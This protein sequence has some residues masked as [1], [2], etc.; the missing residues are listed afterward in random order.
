MSNNYVVQTGSAARYTE[1]F[2]IALGQG[3]YTALNAA[4]AYA[5]TSGVRALDKLF[6]SKMGSAWNEVDKRWLVGIDWCRSDPPAL[7][8]LSAMPHST[9]R[10]PD[11][12]KTVNRKGC[13]PM[14]TYHPKLFTLIGPEKSA[15]ICGSGNLSAN[16][17]TKGCECGSVLVVDSLA[18]APHPELTKLMNWF[19]STWRSATPYADINAIYTKKAEKAI[20]DRQAV[21]TDDDVNPPDH[22]ARDESQLRK[23]CTYDNLWIDAG[24]LGNNLGKGKPGNQLD[25]RRYTRVFFG[26][27]A[28]E[29]PKM[30]VIDKLVLVWGGV[31]YSNCTLKYGDN[32]M[33]KLNVPPSGDRGERFYEKKTLLFTRRTNGKFDFTAGDLADRK[34][35]KRLSGKDRTYTL[36]GKRQREWGVF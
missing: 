8:R 17:L 3:E 1:L 21:P 16:G 14:T 27:P 6:E 13:V 23:L 28:T 10:I 29:V 22:R 32:G 20:K 11:G 4:V 2:D 36:S 12:E 31:E 15:I 30:T 7:A 18:D 26:A 35:W 19:D 33:D 34:I 25:M 5:T 24:G 9:I